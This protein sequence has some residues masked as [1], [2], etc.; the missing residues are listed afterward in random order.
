MPNLNFYWWKQYIPYYWHYP[1]SYYHG[2]QTRY[3]PLDGRR[4]RVACLF[5]KEYVVGVEKSE[6]GITWKHKLLSMIRLPCPSVTR[7]IKVRMTP[8]WAISLLPF[9]RRYR[10]DAIAI[11][12][13]DTSLTSKLA[14]LRFAAE[15][16]GSARIATSA[17]TRRSRELMC[18]FF[19]RKCAE[20]F[21]GIFAVQFYDTLHSL[22]IWNHIDEVSK[23]IVSTIAKHSNV[24][25]SQ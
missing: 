15:T 12:S 10:F 3:L 19:N 2:C 17:D 25:Y 20:L 4:C 22:N 23:E 11:G 5:W 7:M 8:S 18:R 9:E 6:S 1:T 24:C 21:G 13:C 16:E 14:L